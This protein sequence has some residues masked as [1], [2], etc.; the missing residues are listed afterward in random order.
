MMKKVLLK[1]EPETEKPMQRNNLFRTTCKTKDTFCKVIIDSGSIDNLVSTGMVE[2]LEMETTALSTPYKVSW[3]H[4][5]HQVTVTKQCLVN[6]KIGGYR[7]EILCDV[8]PMDV[9]HVLLGRPW[10]Y[11]IN[12]IHDGRRNTYTLKKNGRTHMLLPIE[13][14]RGNQYPYQ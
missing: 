2:N 4:K 7:D 3:L 6:F 1:Q 14:K 11:D 5:G 10:Q 9:Y 13:G 8:I 12:V